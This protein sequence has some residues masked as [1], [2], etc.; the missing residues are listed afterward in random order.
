MTSSLNQNGLETHKD[1]LISTYAYVTRIY[2]AY[3]ANVTIQVNTMQGTTEAL[4]AHL[5]LD[6]MRKM[7][8]SNARH[9]TTT[10]LEISN[11]T[12]L[13][14]WKKLGMKLLKDW[15]MITKQEI[16]LLMK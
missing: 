4:E 6:L 15:K 10:F 9:A 5:T 1:G 14:Y 2:P 16:Y 13:D 7:F 11:Y 8:T 3:H 12:E